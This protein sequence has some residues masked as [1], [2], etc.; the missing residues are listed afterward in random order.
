MYHNHPLQIL[1]HA[2]QHSE[3]KI[4][5]KKWRKKNKNIPY[6]GIYLCLVTIIIVLLIR[7]VKVNYLQN[8]CKAF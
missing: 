1:V 3:T 6:S 2:L 5:Y 8:C 4:M 7:K